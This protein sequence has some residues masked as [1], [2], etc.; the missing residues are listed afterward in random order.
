MI[1]QISKGAFLLNKLFGKINLKLL[2]RLWI[3][4]LNGDDMSK[5]RELFIK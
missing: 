1:K 3:Y 5:E 4:C 2:N